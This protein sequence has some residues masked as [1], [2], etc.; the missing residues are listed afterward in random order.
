[1]AKRRRF[2]E[3]DYQEETND[4]SPVSEG[5]KD[6]PD[7]K[8]GIVCNAKC[9]RVRKEPSSTSDTVCVL[10]RGDEVTILGKHTDSFYEI[11]LLNEKDR[12]GYISCNYCEEVPE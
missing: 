11:S 6:K 5:I 2:S 8:R 12:V 4:G 1:M 10:E 7:T 9:V 3:R